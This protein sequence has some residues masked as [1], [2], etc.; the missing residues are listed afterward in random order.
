MKNRARIFPNILPF[1]SIML[2][3]CGFFHKVPMELMGTMNFPITLEVAPNM[4]TSS[5]IT[6][7]LKSAAN[8]RF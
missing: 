5:W 6:E 2:K 8:V 7:T 3:N 4:E 1:S